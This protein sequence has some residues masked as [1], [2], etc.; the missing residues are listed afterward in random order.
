MKISQITA[1]VAY[2]T[3][4]VVLGRH[5]LWLLVAIIVGAVL[6][7]A[8]RE[9]GDEGARL[10]FSNEPVKQ[11]PPQNEMQSPVYQ[12]LDA[13]NNPYTVVAEK[14]VQKDKD[15]VMLYAIRA[16][17]QQ[18]NHKWLALTAG[19]GQLSITEKKLLLM[20]GVNLFYGDGFE[21]ETEHAQVDIAAGTA[22]GASR[23]T[24]QGPL[25]TLKA[26][27]FEVE[28]R[29]RVI[30]FNGSVRVKVYRKR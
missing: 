11:A 16:D 25:G 23:V 8:S 21:M 24:G 30:R 14:A 9:A 4:L 5:V 1:P 12:G 10:V 19:S 6:W 26:K 27:G 17:M 29:G 2:Y 28:E 7:I 3:R 18:Q 13:K 15:T 22:Y 20:D